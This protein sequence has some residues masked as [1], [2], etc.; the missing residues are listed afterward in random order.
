MDHPLVVRPDRD[1]FDRLATDWPLVPVWAELLAD[2]ATPSRCSLP[3]PGT[4]RDLARVGRAFWAMGSVLL[5]GWRSCRDHGGRRRRSPPAGG[6]AGA[7][8]RET[9]APA[10]AARSPP[11]RGSPASRATGRRPAPDHRRA[12]GLRVV[13]SRDPPR[14]SSGATPRRDAPCPPIGF[15]LI[16]RAVV[17]DHWRQRLVLVAHRPARSLRRRGPSARGA[18]REAPPAPRAPADERRRRWAGATARPTWMTIGTARIVSTFKEHILAGDI[19]QAV[20]S[21]RVTFAA[22]DG[23]LLDLPASPRLQPCAVHVLTCACWG[24]SSPDRHPNP[25]CGWRAAR[26]RTTDRGDPPARPLRRA[27]PLAR[28]TSCSPILSERAEHAMLVDL[29]RND[30]GRVCRTG[31]VRPTELM[32]VERFSA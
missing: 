3:W 29:A 31:T 19:Y 1:T 23:G 14:W 15:L 22:P 25:S 32:Q 30:L 27:R 13:R 24:W 11:R 17:F 21:R 28:S 7:P 10:D 9:V 6:R 16:D 26:H 20:P 12:D 18:G 4:G 5:R 2:V 8:H